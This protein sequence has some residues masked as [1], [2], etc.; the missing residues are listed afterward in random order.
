MP[1]DED[2]T[3]LKQ[4]RLLKLH[5]NEISDVIIG[6]ILECNNAED[7]TEIIDDIFPNA[8]PSEKKK[9]IQALQKRRRKRAGAGKGNQ[10]NKAMH[11]DEALAENPEGYYYR[12]DNLNE[13]PAYGKMSMEQPSSSTKYTR[14]ASANSANK[15]RFIPL[16]SEKGQ[17]Q[18]DGSARLPG[19]HI[20]NCLAQRHELV[21]NCL[22]CGRIICNQEGSGPCLSC[23]NM[24]CTNEE[25]EILSRNSRKSKK[26]Y[27]SLMNANQEFEIQA[28]NAIE[29]RNKLLEYDRSSAQR[30]KVIDDQRDYFKTDRWFSES[31]IKQLKE[32]E[33][34]RNNQLHKSRREMKVTIDLAGRQVVHE[35]DDYFNRVN[36]SALRDD[37]LSIFS[38][39]KR[40]NTK[41]KKDI[42]HPNNPVI[43][44]DKV[45][46]VSIGKHQKKISEPVKSGLKVPSKAKFRLQDRELQ[47]VTDK[48]L[49]LSMHQP[50]ASLLIR[51]IKV[52]EGR[53]WYAS[54]R[55]RLWIASTSKDCEKS[56]IEALEDMYRV[57]YSGVDLDF[58]D[59]YPAGCLLGCVDVLDCLDQNE[60][61]EK[62]PDGESE[63]PYVFIVASPLE[64][65][66]KFPVKGQHKIWKL[67]SQLHNQAKTGVS[68]LSS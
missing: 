44:P 67:E 34:Q 32:L 65:Y 58:P 36:K 61:Q 45:K 57:R 10:G 52:H 41:S 39:T 54:H 12:K 9:F 18:F 46:F 13:L 20:C 47:E 49:C 4:L 37:N 53:T 64:L 1:T 50:W 62:Y 2:V 48:G 43:S 63:S 42:F 38:G 29:H 5:E 3:W 66:V 22:N 21:N 24:V 33:R 19:R 8:D 35:D 40:D 59:S 16:T 26:L 15:K 6:Y 68:F 14:N 31:E 56:D 27:E 28:K 30:T 11:K 51:G 25:K 23:G 60:Y 17:S 7:L 55:G